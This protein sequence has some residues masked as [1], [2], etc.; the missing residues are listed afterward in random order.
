VPTFS[1]QSGD[2][3]RRGLRRGLSGMYAYG[4]FPS[5][6]PTSPYG[7]ART[8][9]SE[10]AMSGGGGEDFDRLKAGRQTSALSGGI[11]STDED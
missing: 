10:G 7:A 1:T 11:N 9:V 2:C 5:L 8:L 3:G 6:A 4:V